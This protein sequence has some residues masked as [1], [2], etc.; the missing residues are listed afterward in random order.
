[1]PTTRHA[2]AFALCLA[3]APAAAQDSWHNPYT[4]RNW[5]NPGSSLIDTFLQN[6]A[7]RRMM[8]QQQGSQPGA[9]AS[10]PGRDP[11]FRLV[12]RGG[13]TINQLYV[14]STQSD[15]WGPDRLGQG[16]LPSGQAFIVR[17]PQGMCANDIR[18]VFADGRVAERRGVD[19]CGITDLALP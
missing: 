16:V 6:D 9:V 3:T 14:S 7:R 4:G 1:M 19:T 8:M 12:N 13:A 15:Q 11:S 5:N 18:A 2:A 10:Q 17:L